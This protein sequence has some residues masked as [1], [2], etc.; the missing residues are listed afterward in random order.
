[1]RPAQ[2]S[3]TTYFVRELQFKLNETF[4]PLTPWSTA[5]EDFDV[6]R[7][8]TSKTEDRRNWDVNLRLTFN[9]PPERNSPCTF[10]IDLTGIVQVDQTVK[11]E[12]IERFIHINGTSLVFGA[13][14]EI[15]RSIT[16]YGPSKPIW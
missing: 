6:K 2:I 10:M 3:L 4:E 13:A 12:N 7:N 8:A 9:P 16:S 1:M 14:R 11:D 15:I 5:L